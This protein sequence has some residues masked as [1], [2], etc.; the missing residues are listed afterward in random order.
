M[1]LFNEKTIVS[2]TVNLLLLLL[3]FLSFIV[4]NKSTSSLSAAI[5]YSFVNA[6]NKDCSR[7]L[8]D[9][10]VNYTAHLV[11]EPDSLKD[12][13]SKLLFITENGVQTYRYT[14]SFP[15]EE[16]MSSRNAIYQKALKDINKINPDTLNC[17]FQKEL[18][19][20]HISAETAVTYTEKG[21]KTI[22]GGDTDL[23]S[24]WGIHQSLRQIIDIDSL[25]TLQAY[26]PYSINLVVSY[27]PQ[28]EFMGLISVIALLFAIL[29]YYI[30]KQIFRITSLKDIENIETIFYGPR[31]L[32][33]SNSQKSLDCRKEMLA[34]PPV[35]EIRRLENGDYQIGH[36][37]FKTEEMELW[38]YNGRKRLH[39]TIFYRLLFAFMETPENSL[40]KLKIDEIYKN[41][42]DEAIYK[43]ISRFR[44]LFNEDPSIKVVSRP[45]GGYSMKIN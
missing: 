20:M 34:L 44:I 8:A 13:D 6:I 5:E 35:K 41:K 39:N 16:L 23:I 17:L 30:G 22:K 10:K 4:Y 43:S 18:K 2:I 37:L 26:V 42:N 29:F 31:E 11:T 7:R 12:G 24:S 1:A 3:L 28:K 38:G 21:K 19:R 45:E 25:I 27:A 36:Y 40:S 32:S 33:W 14:D 9:P 15:K